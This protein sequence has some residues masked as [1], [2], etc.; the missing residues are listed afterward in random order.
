M[1]APA[2]SDEILVDYITGRSISNAGAE[3]NRQSIERFLVEEKGYAPGEIE[4][5]AELEMVIDGMCCKAT[6]D[7][8][9]RVNGCRYMAIKCAAGSLASRERE[10]IAAARLL[11]AYQLPLSVAS[12]GTTALVWDTVSGRLVGE[13]MTAIPLKSD[14]AATFNPDKTVP[15]EKSRRHRQMLIFRTYATQSCAG[16]TP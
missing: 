5:D 12:D 3:M 9:V 11:D 16:A 13:E 14:A 4:V 7:L 10:V 15:L 2:T 6:V 1:N 8:V